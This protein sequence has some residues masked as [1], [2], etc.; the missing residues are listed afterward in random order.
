MKQLEK[1]PQLIERLQKAVG[2]GVNL[3]DLAVY[4]AVALNTVPLRKRH[5]LYKGAVV[6]ED[7]LYSMAAQLQQDMLPLQIMHEARQLP[8]GRVFWGNVTL[9]QT[10]PEL[11]VQFFLPKSNVEI[12]NKIETAT[13]D[14][15]S[16]SLLTNH[17]LCSECGW[18]YLGEEASYDNVWRGTC[19]NDH[20]I[21]KNGAHVRLVGLSVFSE[22]SLVGRGGA[23]GAKIQSPAS[24]KLNAD[25]TPVS[26]LIL[27]ASAPK[28]TP[29]VTTKTTEIAPINVVELVADLTTQKAAVVSKDAE[30]ATLTA[31]ITEKDARI[32][33][34]EAQVAAAPKVEPDV[35]ALQADVATATEFLKDVCIKSLTA[36]GVQAPTAPDSVSELVEKITEIQATLSAVFPVGGRAAPATKVEDKTVTVGLGAFTAPRNR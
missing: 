2:E 25:G 8:E 10:G 5:P 27:N 31:S 21:G 6:G 4:E 1:T 9:A 24:A 7:V 30:I 14:E 34:L 17:A 23:V 15:V 13:I 35:A 20:V 26:P 36:S 32:A 33:E 22:L 19:A 28:E 29:A 18:D 12:L 16:V 11:R 3:D